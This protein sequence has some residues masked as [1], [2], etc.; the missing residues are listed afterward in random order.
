VCGEEFYP[1]DKWQIRKE[2]LL[3]AEGA[4]AHRFLIYACKSY[5]KTDI[6]VINFGGITELK[7]F[8][9]N[10]VEIMAGFSKVKALVVARDAEADVDRAMIQVTS[11]LQTVKLPVP[12]QPFQF[13]SNGHIKTAVVFFPGP[14]QNGKCQKGTLEELCLKTIDDV[15]LLEC[16]EAFLQCAKKSNEDLKHPWKSKLYAYLAGKDAHAGKRL[17][18]AARDKVWNLNHSSMEPF[19][20]IIREM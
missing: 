15:A 8:L 13:S 6:Q 9:Q 11:A 16:V 12:Q 18:Q 14:D 2:K 7:V 19:K 5:K 20:K 3:L 10:L 4:D 1:A 17:G